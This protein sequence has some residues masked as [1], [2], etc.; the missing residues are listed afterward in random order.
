MDVVNLAKAL[1]D[2]NRVRVVC[3]L[4]GRELC[5]CDLIARLGLAQATVS[6]H[7]SLLVAAGLVIG[8]REG[9]W[10]HYRLPG[11]GDGASPAVKDAL[12]WALAHAGESAQAVEDEAGLSK[13]CCE[14]GC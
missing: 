7:M 9:R 6:R 11:R 5:A 1:S 10:T 4:R 12:K 14:T 13:A 8:R 2:P 3:M